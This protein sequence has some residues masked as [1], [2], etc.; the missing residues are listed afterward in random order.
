MTAASVI[1]LASVTGWHIILPL[2]ALYAGSLGA[3]PVQVGLLVSVMTGIASFLC[4]FLGTLADTLG[5]GRLARVSA[6]AFAGALVVVIAGRDLWVLAVGLAALGI[7]NIALVIATESHV[8]SATALGDRVRAFSILAAWS[9]AGTLI[10]PV[11][12]GT[13]ALRWGFSAAFGTALLISMA[14]VA[15]SW[16]IHERRGRAMRSLNFLAGYRDAGKVLRDRTIALILTLSFAAMF[17]YSLRQSFYP[18]HLKQVG[19]TTATIGTAMAILGL[20]TLVVRPVLPSLLAWLGPVRVMALAFC[21][22]VAG[23][24]ATP[25]V[26]TFWPVVGA[27]SLLGVAMGLLGPLSTILIAERVRDGTYGQA[28]SLRVMSLQAAQLVSPTATGF[29]VSG[30]GLHAAFYFAAI[31][32]AGALAV[33]ARFARGESR[34]RPVSGGEEA[35]SPH[36]RP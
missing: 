15:A 5:A 36:S 27:L 13:I 30:F 31:V 14:S 10:G 35:S 17:S 18:V 1:T 3:S 16:T 7:S 29:V 21:L 24:A 32:S 34:D 22:M 4:L 2:L 8:A 12:G 33:L 6:L 25:S 26:A 28:I 9:S 20:A 11:L 23:L 19:F